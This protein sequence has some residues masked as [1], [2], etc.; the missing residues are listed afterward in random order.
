MLDTNTNYKAIAIQ[1]YEKNIDGFFNIG[2]VK[3]TL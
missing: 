2:V 3:T 1:F